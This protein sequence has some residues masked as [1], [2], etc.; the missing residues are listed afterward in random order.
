MA[1]NNTVI[2]VDWAV[3][4]D[5]LKNQMAQVPGIGAKEAKA[6]TA[7]LSREMRAAEAAA[8]KAAKGTESSWTKSFST[9]KAG[10]GATGFGDLAEKAEKVGTVMEALASPVGVAVGAFV[11]LGAATAAGVAALGAAVFASDEALDSLKGFKSIG[12]DFY[13]AVPA[14]T[15][16]SIKAVNASTDALGS[17]WDRLVVDVGANVAPAFERVADVATGL[18]LTAMDA[19]EAFTKGKSLLHEFAVFMVEQVVNAI[20]SPITPLEKLAEGIVL[21][22]HLAG[23]TLPAGVED[24]LTSFSQLNHSIA[25]NTVSFYEGAAAGS[26]LADGFDHLADR[27]SK[28]ITTQERATKAV[29]DGKKG[30]DEAAKALKAL[31][32]EMARQEKLG[33]ENR[34]TYTDALD[35]MMALEDADRKAI[36]TKSEQMAIDHEAALQEL[37][38]LRDQALAVATTMSARE[39]AEQEYRNASKAE[40]AAYYAE[41][42]KYDDELEKA[43]AENARKAAETEKKY[44]K[45]AVKAAAGI[46]GSISDISSSASD[47]YAKNAEDLRQYLE[48]NGDQL[49]ASEQKDYEDRIAQQEQ[50]ALDSF[51][52]SQASAAVEAA[53]NTAMAVSEALSASPY[54]YNLIPAG[55][56][57]AAGVAEE[58]AIASESPPSFGDTPGVQQMQDGGTVRLASG[59]Y[60]AAAK[61]PQE[62][63]RQVGGGSPTVYVVAK[64]G[65]KT[66]DAQVARDIQS[67]GRLAKLAANTRKWRRAS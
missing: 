56:A 53:I 49:T 1:G 29:A 19:F 4:L 38:D 14:S 39:T 31:N 18:A 21:A 60:F 27:G 16:A 55:L 43:R 25:E 36:A 10:A 52:V 44:Q 32:D 13:P 30:A 22:A 47:I 50:A 46:V 66:F 40:N 15:L 33:E 12:S 51:Y 26:D 6:L 28:F 17:I 65:H 34:K 24:A 54:P 2:G 11:A 61:D 20:L 67:G 64:V 23:A 35:K 42:K 48:D 45:A 59:D 37:A 5:S 9:I 8:S 7:Q 63:Q 62:L 58:V 41:L 3:R 57:L